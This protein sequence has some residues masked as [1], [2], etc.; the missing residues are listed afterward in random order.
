[1][2]V[3]VIDALGCRYIEQI[4]QIPGPNPLTVTANASSASCDV[5]GNG[6]ITYSIGGFTGANVNVTVIN[7]QTGNTVFV[8]TS[9]PS[10]G[11]YPDITGLPPGNYQIIVEENTSSCRAS[12][13][14]TIIQDT[15]SI[16]IDSNTNA[17]CNN[18]NGQLVIR[19]VGG[20][21]GYTFAIVT[22][23]NA[24]P[25]L[26]DYVATTS[27]DLAPGFYDIYVRDSRGC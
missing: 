16:T 1:Y 15:P 22:A 27:Y 6:V 3:E 21:P 12:D 17:T 20:T 14:V 26:G 5:T 25:A 7:T 24:D 4:D 13:L 11:P 8:P 2:F 19:G 18:P 10:A 9:V 23:G